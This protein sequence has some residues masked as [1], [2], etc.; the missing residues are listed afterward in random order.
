MIL[1]TSL[2][3]SYYRGLNDSLYCL[4][5]FLLIVIVDYTPNPILNNYIRPLRYSSASGFR[6]RSLEGT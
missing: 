4:G 2:R 3:D 1:S 5:G 6:L